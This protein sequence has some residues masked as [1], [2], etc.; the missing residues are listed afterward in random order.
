MRLFGRRRSAPAVVDLLDDG[1]LV[2]VA[3][4]F[5]P[6][7]SDAAAVAAMG[8]PAGTPVLVRQHFAG[9][10]EVSYPLLVATVA[11][12]GWTAGSLQPDATVV[13]TATR[14]L[15]PLEASQA[16]ARMAGMAFRLGADHVGW[17]AL[18]A[19]PEP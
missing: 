2:L 15:A 8:V 1:S 18:V 11:E 14:V 5:D 7:G 12:D 16:R 17:D 9:V 10:T 4:V 13:A 3:A 19:A 6:A